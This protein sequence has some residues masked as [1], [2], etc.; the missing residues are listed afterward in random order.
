MATLIAILVCIGAGT[1]GGVFFAFSSFVMKALAALPAPQAVSAMQSINVVVLN[2]VFLGVFMGTALLSLVALVV[3]VAS[4]GTR[5]AWLLFLAG[6][7]YLIGSF[8]VTVLFNVPRNERLRA[9]AADSNDAAT[10]WPTYLSE[11]MRWNQ[12]RTLASLASAAC[13]AGALA[14]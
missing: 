1:I 2:R 13:A 11:W 5:P 10:Y 6:A 12:L 3:A 4:W 8:G 9:M 7:L 14:L